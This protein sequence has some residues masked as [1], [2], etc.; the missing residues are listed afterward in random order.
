MHKKTEGKFNRI[1]VNMASVSVYRSCAKCV[2][3]TKALIFPTQDNGRLSVPAIELCNYQ[4]QQQQQ[5]FIN[6]QINSQKYC[7]Q[8]TRL[9]EAGQCVQN[10]KIETKAINIIILS[11]GLIQLSGW[12]KLRITYLSVKASSEHCC[13]MKGLCQNS[14]L[15]LAPTPDP[16]THC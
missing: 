1:Y 12:G 5:N 3:R 4:Q 7:P 10:I 11:R 8:L 2:L 15:I 16:P 9:F 14:P 6:K 13:L